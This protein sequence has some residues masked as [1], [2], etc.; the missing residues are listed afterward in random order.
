MNEHIVKINR[1]LFFLV[2]IT[3]VL[4]YGK[5]ILIPLFF[6]IMLAMLMDQYVVS[7]IAKAYLGRFPV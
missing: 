1:T 5:P 2:L 4:Y 3:V 6:A 7:L